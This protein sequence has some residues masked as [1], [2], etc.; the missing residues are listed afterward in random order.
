[1][2]FNLFLWSTL[3][4][5]LLIIYVLSKKRHLAI[6]SIFFRLLWI[7][8]CTKTW[9]H[10]IIR[11]SFFYFYIFN[12]DLHTLWLIKWI[13]SFFGLHQMNKLWLKWT[14][15]L[16]V[17]EI[18]KYRTKTLNFIYIPTSFC[19]SAWYYWLLFEKSR[20]S[21][22]HWIRLQTQSVCLTTIDIRRLMFKNLCNYWVSVRNW[23]CQISRW[24]ARLNIA[25]IFTMFQTHRI[26]NHLSQLF[27]RS[28]N[29]LPDLELKKSQ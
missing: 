3:W 25:A 11:I 5:W 27:Y 1:M 6:I 12:W 19:N 20:V 2:S 16:G 26:L 28:Q 7:L 23:L 22:L 4:F 14:F 9:R 8:S 13:Q 18:R 24:E 21:S 17:K 10:V 29:F 15:R